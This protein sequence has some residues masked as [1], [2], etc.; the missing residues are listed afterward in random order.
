MKRTHGWI[1]LILF[2]A[3]CGSKK[4][5]P[6]QKEI[7]QDV[8]Q[9]DEIIVGNIADRLS[10]IDNNHFMEDSVPVYS[11]NLL[12]SFY[13]IYEN[14]P[15]WSNNGQASGN[16]KEL[17]SYVQ[18]AEYVGLPP[19]RYH[20]AALA[21]ALDQLHNDREAKKDAA[22]WA[23]MDVM[24]TDA[25]MKLANDLHYGIAPRDSNALRKDSVFSDMDMIEMLQAALQSNSLE[26]AFANLEPKHAGYVGLKKEWKAFKDLYSQYTWDTLPSQYTDTVAFR[27]LL[28]NRLVQTAHLDTT[29]GRK[30]T[31]AIRQAVKS[32]QT[33]FN[34]YPDGVAGK[35]TIQLLNRNMNDWF[36]QAAVN[37]DR[38]R[39][40][41]DSLPVRLLWVN[42]PAYNME[43]TDSNEVVLS[44]RVIVGTPKTRTPI[45][46]ST[47]TN[48]VLYP[49]W[50][51][52]YSIV[53][54]EMLPQIKKDVGYLH[55]KNL[56]VINKDGEAVDPYSIDWSKLSKNYFPYV[57]R[58]MDGVDNSLGVMK[59]NFQNPYHVYLHDTNSR[60]LFKNSYRALSHGCVR[61]QQWDS[62]AMYLVRNDTI[63]HN[64]RDSVRTWLARGE[65]KQVNFPGRLPIYIR[66]FTAEARDGKMQFY[67]DIYGEDKTLRKA[68][69]L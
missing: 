25:F 8:R 52:P 6:K 62:L 43:L 34:V 63:R 36:A 12:Q 15:K 45:L 5:P 14:A 29:G 44:S 50:R 59:F 19:K 64:T 47:M 66:Y 26:T 53:F 33:E 9:L 46:I 18:N 67:E 10:Y 69:G 35:K 39:K 32:F 41:P 23:R 68:M 7:V 55:K 20:A 40:L 58:Q 2:L 16:L 27:E 37:L 4:Q 11:S 57:L 17:V 56:E 38:W 21:A 49:Y 24:A 65:K 1:L 31:S 51:V 3:A 42:I 48:F 30:D 22:L 60:G 61:V 54:K 28:A 13:E